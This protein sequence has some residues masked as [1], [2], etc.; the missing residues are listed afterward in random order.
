MRLS[1]L[2]V[3]LALVAC[4]GGSG[5]GSQ[6]AD[7][8]L[9]SQGAVT[10]SGNSPINITIPSGGQVHFFNKD[11]APH[12]ITSPECTELNSPQLAPNQDFLTSIGGGPRA[13]TFK[14]SL[15]PSAPGFNGNIT[16]GD[17][18]TPGGGY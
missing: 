9:T 6:V 3:T 1:M 17:T 5:G 12:K 14:D 8:N 10:A 13:C 4:G 7:I 15:N 18:G 2:L 16:V 11:T